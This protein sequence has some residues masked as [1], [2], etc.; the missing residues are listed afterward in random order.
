MLEEDIAGFFTP[1]AKAVSKPPEW[2]VKDVIPVGLTF[3]GAP[4][5][6]TKST[7][8]MALC[9][10]VAEWG[11]KAL[12]P[13]LSVVERVGPV[14]GLSAEAT[15]G[16]LRNMIEV[17]LGVEV[18]DDDGIVVAD[19]P[20]KFRLD[21][22][23]ALEQLLSWLEI[24]K[25]RLVFI[26]PLRDFHQLEEKD[27]GEMNRL[28]RPLRQW[29]VDNEA[30]LLIVHHAKKKE[31]PTAIYTAADLRGSSALFGICDG[32]LMLTPLKNGS[33]HIEA[34]FKRAASWSRD[35]MLAAYDKKG[36]AAH[37]MLGVM[38]Q[39]VLYA[40]AAGCKTTDE[41][42]KRVKTAKG[43]VIKA[44]QLL[45]GNNL[46][47]QEGKRFVLTGESPTHQFKHQTNKR[48]SDANQS[49]GAGDVD[50]DGGDG[51]ERRNARWAARFG[52]AN[53]QD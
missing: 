16:E 50:G 7:F 5:K 9:A 12:P 21:D 45:V 49:A 2:V 18:K 11:G 35:F 29:A 13:H 34:T 14:L 41:V 23:G 53:P 22:P 43:N 17:G 20:W 30:A 48:G 40:Y 39:E 37:E 47:R 15:A 3:I 28:L 6:S 24:L 38:E 46:L 1:L 4:P 8:V 33:L 25:P 27:S 44:V 19:D 42:A 32:V 51:R 26:D 52:G 10:L 31:D 36:Q